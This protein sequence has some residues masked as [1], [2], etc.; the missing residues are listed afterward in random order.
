[1][2][3]L[4][5]LIALLSSVFA[6]TTFAQKVEKLLAF[7]GVFKGANCMFF[8]KE[9]PDD[10]PEGHIATEPDF[11]LV[12]PE[13]KYF[14]IVNLDR[15]VKARYFH[16]NVRVIGK[17]NKKGSIIADKL[18]IKKKDKWKTVWSLKREQAEREKLYEYL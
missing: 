3:K 14:Y 15:A 1:M 7:D 17:V 16:K 18:Q 11:V 5:I 6:F 2:K 10:M 8:N 9:C 4:S 13:G 12:L